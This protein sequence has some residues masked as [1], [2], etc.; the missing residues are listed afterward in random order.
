MKH[1]LLLLLLVLVDLLGDPLPD[2]AVA[3]LGTT[4][5]RHEGAAC[6]APCGT[7]LATGGRGLAVFE[8]PSGRFLIDADGWDVTALAWGP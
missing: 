8:L 6:I 5:L 3:R 1:L 4:R 2:G 7:W